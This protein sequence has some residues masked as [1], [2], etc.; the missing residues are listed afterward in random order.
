MQDQRQHPRHHISW[1]VAIFVNRS[2]TPIQGKTQ[3]ISLGGVSI[4]Q[5]LNLTP[6]TPCRLIFEIP[7]ADFKSRKYLELEASVVYAS[8]V[9]GTS[10]YRT[11]FSF[12][13]A[14]SQLKDIIHS[15]Q[16]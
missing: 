1:R 16:R 10:E 9:G 2:T 4:F 6:N 12:K 13:Q 5:P 3:E 8:L 11:G 7:S 15:L 14:D